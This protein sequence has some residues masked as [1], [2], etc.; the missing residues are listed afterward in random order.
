MHTRT[1]VGR[2]LAAGTGVTAAVLLAM[3]GVVSVPVSSAQA[4]TS[5]Q[6]NAAPETQ[7]GDPQPEFPGGSR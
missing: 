6:S 1:R 2:R 7:A 3:A 4:P 5:T